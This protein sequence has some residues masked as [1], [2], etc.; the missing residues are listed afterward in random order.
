MFKSILKKALSLYLLPFRRNEKLLHYV[1]GVFLTDGAEHLYWAARYIKKREAVSEDSVVIDV[2]GF[3]GG[4]SVYFTHQF[5]RV[6]V[7]CVEPNGRMLPF[8]K[9][10]ESRHENI[11]VKRLALGRVSGE[12]LLHVTSNNLSSSLNE[13]N[14]E[15]IARTPGGFQA[16]LKEEEEMPVRVSTLDDEFGDCPGV[17]LIKLDTQGTELEILKGGAEVLKRTKFILTEMN[18]HKLY[19][20]TCQYY[21][22]DEYLRLNSFRLV[23]LVVSYRGDDGVTEYDALY[24]NTNL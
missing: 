17:L 15:E 16:M 14:A 11:S 3:D 10:V 20:S 13:L 24:E 22:V 6:K 4:T 19:E 21:E 7:F 5:G 12:A 8:L 9:D 1:R 18:N 2:G 23:D